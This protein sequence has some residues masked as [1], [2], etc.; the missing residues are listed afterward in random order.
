MKSDKKKKITLNFEK[1]PYKRILTFGDVAE[2]RI[3]K[4]PPQAKIML[5]TSCDTRCRVL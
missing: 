5:S 4:M 1:A 3:G 2:E